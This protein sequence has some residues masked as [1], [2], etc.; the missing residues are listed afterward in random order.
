MS[1]FKSLV[2]LRE[3]R[4]R[5]LVCCHWNEEKGQALREIDVANKR[6]VV[7]AR[8]KAEIKQHLG[9]YKVANS[10]DYSQIHQEFASFPP[11]KGVAIT[12]KSRWLEIATHFLKASRNS[13]S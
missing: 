5:R 3:P 7:V 9:K 1:R 6:I 11:G 10:Y 13:G 4:T 2:I 12:W 8:G